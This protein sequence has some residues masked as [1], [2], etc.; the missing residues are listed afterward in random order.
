MP[1]NEATYNKKLRSDRIISHNPRPQHMIPDDETFVNNFVATI[2]NAGSNTMFAQIMEIKYNDYVVDTDHLRK[3]SQLTINSLKE[4]IQGNQPIEIDNT[5]GQTTSD[6]WYEA[7]SL[8]VTASNAKTV[9]TTKSKQGQYNLLKRL[10]WS[11]KVLD[12]K[13]LKYG[14]DNEDHAFKN[15]Q[16][17]SLTPGHALTKSGFWVNPKYPE[18][19]CS[20]D[21]L[22][23][24]CN[25]KLVGVLEIKCPLVLENSGP[26]D[27]ENLSK[28]QINN[29]C[30]KIEN[31]ELVLNRTHSYYFQIQM[32][33]AIC[34]VDFCDFSIWSPKGMCIERIQRD[35][36]FW[37]ALFPKLIDFH[38]NILVPEYFEQRIPR[39]LLPVNLSLDQPS[40]K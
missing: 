17:G 13:A 25:K 2:P 8:R 14:R 15:F 33:I 9:T 3:L 11:K 39:R 20:P 36:G 18:L 21:G 19:G 26:T 30:Y 1:Y 7:R 5:K 10:L 16:E 6:S 24:D 22:I 29:L 31:G 12:L 40:D 34:G 28:N 27:L 35:I 4:S 32:Q 23:W 37:N 38:H